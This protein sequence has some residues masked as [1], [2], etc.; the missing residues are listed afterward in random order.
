MKKFFFAMLL[1]ATVAMAGTVTFTAQDNG[2]GTATVSYTADAAVVGFA[3]DVDSDVDVTDVAID[4]F[5]DVFMDYANAEGDAYVYGA[6]SPIAAQEAA[7][8]AA[9]PAASFCISAGGLEDDETDVPALTGEI[10]ITTGA[11]ASVT[12]GENALRG[13]VVDY[14]GAMTTNLPITFDITAGGPE[15]IAVPDVTGMTQTAAEAA[16]TGAGLAVGTVTTTETGATEA[17]DG[18]VASQDPAAANEVEAGTAVDIVLYEYVAAPPACAAYDINGDGM[19]FTNDITALVMYLNGIG[20][21]YLVP[22]VT[23]GVNDQYDV[24]GDGMVFTND[25]T[26]LVMYLNGIGAP[27]LEPCAY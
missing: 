6:G 21:P 18:T 5:F 22:A 27:Y 7:G 14:D 12:L 16:I 19:V 13:G 9:L 17:N 26:A 23:D 20:A 4:S 10:V 1:V 24:N 25:I 2:D 15:L 11:A 8:V 3:L